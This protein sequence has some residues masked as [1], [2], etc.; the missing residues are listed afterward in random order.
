MTLSLKITTMVLIF[1]G[2]MNQAVAETPATD[3]FVEAQ[4]NWADFSA[5]NQANEKACQTVR[6]ALEH[7][8][9]I[10]LANQRFYELLLSDHNG[11]LAMAVENT[12][13]ELTQKVTETTALMKTFVA[14]EPEKLIQ[15]A[16]AL[17]TLCP[18]MFDQP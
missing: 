11:Y 9:G 12:D 2:A 3:D 6:E 13:A 10:N 14:M 16:V 15:S 8:A 7:M 18:A 5:E 1:A 4:K 17:K